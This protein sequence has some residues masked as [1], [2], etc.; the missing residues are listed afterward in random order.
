ML[1]P[2]LCYNKPC[3]KE[4][5]VYHC[6]LLKWS[7]ECLIMSFQPVEASN[8]D[9][10]DILLQAANLLKSLRQQTGSTSSEFEVDTAGR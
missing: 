9:E 3:Y 4:V 6:T 8:G 5:E 1:Y 10:I 7:S 2:K